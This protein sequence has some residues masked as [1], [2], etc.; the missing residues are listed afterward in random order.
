[1][2]FNPIIIKS[3]RQANGLWGMPMNVRSMRLTGLMSD[4]DNYKFSA[5]ITGIVEIHGNGCNLSIEELSQ[6]SYIKIDVFNSNIWQSDSKIYIDLNDY[7]LIDN[8]LY[9]IKT[10][11]DKL[12]F[13]R[14]AKI[15]KIKNEFFSTMADDS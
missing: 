8:K 7:G 15:K 9:Y 12:N 3:K 2:K 11:E 10:D 4:E 14:I 1:M 6:T 5:I 13:Y